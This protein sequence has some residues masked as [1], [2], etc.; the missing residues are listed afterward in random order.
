MEQVTSNRPA[1]CYDD[2]AQRERGVY[3]HDL[4]QTLCRA[5]FFRER[6]LRLFRHADLARLRSRATGVSAGQAGETEG[7]GPYLL[8]RGGQALAALE[9]WQG[10]RERCCPG[11]SLP[12]IT[13]L[14]IQRGGETKTV[15]ALEEVMDVWLYVEARWELPVEP[16]AARLWPHLVDAGL[17]ERHRREDGT[18][19]WDVSAAGRD[20]GLC[21]GWSVED[22]KLREGPFGSA[23]ARK[24]LKQAWPANREKGRPLDVRLWALER[25]IYA[26]SEVERFARL[27]IGAFLRDYPK[28]L[29][30]IEDALGVGPD[31]PFHQVAAL[32]QERLSIPGSQ[33]YDEAVELVFILACPF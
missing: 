6:G 29:E 4:E 5:D 8:C 10:T 19:F 21:W 17:V 30:K 14:S 31:T 16:V 7:L 26:R 11:S 28:E 25:G 24:W 32:V 27:E 9:P 15:E 1:F 18:L 22:G 33:A 12:G 3:D 23:K 13:M 20:M 2:L